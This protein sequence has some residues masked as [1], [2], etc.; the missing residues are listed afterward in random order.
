[1][2]PY[3]PLARA[4]DHQHRRVM[5]SQGRAILLLDTTQIFSA[6]GVDYMVRFTTLEFRNLFPDRS[7]SG[8]GV[9]RVEHQHKSAPKARRWARPVLGWVDWVKRPV[10]V[11]SP[12]VRVSGATDDW[13]LVEFDEVLVLDSGQVSLTQ[14]VELETMLVRII[15]NQNSKL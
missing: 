14:R 7:T 2:E 11:V 6:P 3:N 12:F 9:L 8:S 5:A 1:M 10:W 4:L 15:R 13:I